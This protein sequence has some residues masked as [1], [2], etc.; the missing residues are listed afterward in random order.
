MVKTVREIVRF[1]YIFHESIWRAVVV[2]LASVASW[3]YLTTIYL[4]SCTIFNLVCNLQVLHFEDYGKLLEQDADPLVYVQEHLRLRYNLYKI[5]HRF[6]IFLLLVFLCVTA[7]QFVILFETTGHGGTVNFTSAADIAVSLMCLF[8]FICSKHL[9]LV[10][11]RLS[12]N[13]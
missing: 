13:S 1:V 5:S 10:G 2:L 3:T 11:V 7:S 9:L 12:D 4:S 6:R 8:I